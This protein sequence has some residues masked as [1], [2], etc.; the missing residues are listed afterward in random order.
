MT[1]LATSQ[2]GLQVVATASDATRRRLLGE[3]FQRLSRLESN[4]IR[5]QRLEGEAR[6]LSLEVNRCARLTLG[7]E[8]GAAALSRKLGDRLAKAEY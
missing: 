2:V 6:E 4:V 7:I 1:T 8:C 3:M 5:L